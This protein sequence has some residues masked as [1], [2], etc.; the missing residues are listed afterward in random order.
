[1]NPP[2]PDAGARFLAVAFLDEIAAAPDLLED[3][4]QLFA[5]RSDCSLVV[6]AE[7]FEAVDLEPVLRPIAEAHATSPIIISSR[8]ADTSSEVELFR[9]FGSDLHAMEAHSA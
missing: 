1:M 7:G 6:L 2:E 4:A 3:Y 5:G 8:E 9:S